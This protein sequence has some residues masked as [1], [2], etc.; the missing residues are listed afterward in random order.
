MSGLSS[1][2]FVSHR[3]HQSGESDQLDESDQSDVSGL[4]YCLFFSIVA[5]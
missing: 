3:E 1:L 4:F 2:F 5:V